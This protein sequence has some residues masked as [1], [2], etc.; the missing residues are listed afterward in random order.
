M[1]SLSRNRGLPAAIADPWDVDGFRRAFDGAGHQEVDV[2][3]PAPRLATRAAGYRRRRRRGP[4]GLPNISGVF[5]GPKPALASAADWISK[6]A[7]LDTEPD[8]G[9]GPG[10][11]SWSFRMFQWAKTAPAC[12]R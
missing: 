1:G 7:C 10:G 5:H 3:P 8:G 6:C 9:R 2:L 12:L 11:T 4:D